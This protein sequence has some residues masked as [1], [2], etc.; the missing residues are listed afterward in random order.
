MLSHVSRGSRDK[1]E[2][3]RK[4]IIATVGQLVKLATCFTLVHRHSFIRLLAPYIS[5]SV[6]GVSGSCPAWWSQLHV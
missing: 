1:E 4:K 6:T 3:E 2:V 5:A